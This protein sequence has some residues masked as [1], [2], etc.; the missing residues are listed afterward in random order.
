MPKQQAKSMYKVVQAEIEVSEPVLG[1]QITCIV[2]ENGFI[3]AGTINSASFCL[4]KLSDF[5]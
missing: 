4:R 3:V 1:L 2:A 5:D